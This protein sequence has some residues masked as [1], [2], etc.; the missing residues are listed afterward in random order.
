MGESVGVYE[1]ESIGVCGAESTNQEHSGTGEERDKAEGKKH[2]TG[3]ELAKRE[4]GER[5]RRRNGV[6]RCLEGKGQDT[7][8]PVD[9]R[10]HA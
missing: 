3:C 4:S 2:R 8:L 5:S 9:G 7:R 6:G 10:S 1:P